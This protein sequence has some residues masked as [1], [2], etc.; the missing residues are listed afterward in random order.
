VAIPYEFATYQQVSEQVYS[1]LLQHTKQVQPLSCDEAYLDVT[2]LGDPGLI[3]VQIRKQV[4]EA[5]GCSASIGIG[6]SLLA[7][8]IATK[9][10]KPDGIFLVTPEVRVKPRCTN[11][12]A[13]QSESC[14]HCELQA[15]LLFICRQKLFVQSG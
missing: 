5:T 14:I 8:R 6:P 4:L 9:H 13:C 3:A 12:H 10:A 15:A 7:A 1:I 11:A 2:G